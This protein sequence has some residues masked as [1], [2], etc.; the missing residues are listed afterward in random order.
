MTP[1]H[2][3]HGI[4]E[5][6]PAAALTQMITGYWLTQMLYV[7]AR[8][9]IAD[10]LAD[11]PLSAAVLSERAGVH[12]RS[13]YRLMRA[14]AGLN[15]FSES[16]DGRFGHT[17]MSAL[18]RRDLP[19]SLHG[20]ALYSGD[21]RQQRY[22]VWGEL[23]ECV[24]T[25]Q[26]AFAKLLGTTPFAYL[27]QHP[28]LAHDFDRAMDSYASECSAAVLAHYDFGRFRHVVDV[29]GGGGRM[30]SEILLQYESPQ[31]TVFD[32][33]DVAARARERF[34]SQGLAHRASAEAGDFFDGVPAG[35]D[36]YLLK[37]VIHDW[38]DDRAVTILRNCR[39]AMPAHGRLLLAETV[40]R[41]GG[42]DSFGRL[43]DL[44]MMVIHGGLER[45]EWEFSA[46]LARAGFAVCSLRLTG[47]AV[48]LVEARPV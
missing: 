31:G 39:R 11:G 28:E 34:A 36:L 6:T 13:L 27:K 19:G 14:L 32:L 30:L 46:L 4:A 1:S 44:N 37:C 2:A 24:K 7:V 42:G 10:A 48:D 9:E 5:T 18:L 29:G 15:V 38:E 23:H 47:A 33:P 43:M 26:P 17:P 20:L 40:I 21:P 45:A 16:D 8:L 22:R 41:Q 3:R 25:G 12:P 35:G